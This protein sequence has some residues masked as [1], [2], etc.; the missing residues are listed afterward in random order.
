MSVA[1][2]A[3]EVLTIL[4]YALDPLYRPGRYLAGSGVSWMRE[5]GLER[6]LDSLRQNGFVERQKDASGWV[7][8]LTDSG[9]RFLSGTHDPETRWKRPWDGHWRQIIFDLPSRQRALR[10]ELLRWLKANHFGYLQDSLWITPDPV[11]LS[12]PALA[13]MGASADM[14]VFLESRTIGTSSN[15]AMVMAS[16]NFRRIFAAHK[17]YQNFVRTTLSRKRE[18]PLPAG[19]VALL[20]QEHTL[21][22]ETLALDPLLPKAL[23]PEGYPGRESLADRRRFFEGMREQIAR[24]SKGRS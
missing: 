17:D 5:N 8:S 23:W 2:R 24:S 20:R 19:A 16:W 9:R 14:A 1:L 22:H 4:C 18:T 3:I 6:R 21:W 13:K 10:A 7:Y 15:A 12:L 11:N